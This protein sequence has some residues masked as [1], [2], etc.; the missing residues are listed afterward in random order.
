MQ[1]RESRTGSPFHVGQMSHIGRHYDLEIEEC[2]TRI[3]LVG[4]EYGK[5]QGCVSLSKRSER[6][7]LSAEE[8]FWGATLT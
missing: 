1:Y 6:I 3:V 4:Q 7:S 5:T 8:G 2:P